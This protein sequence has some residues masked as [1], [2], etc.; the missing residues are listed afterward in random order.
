MPDKRL[1]SVY[2]AVNSY[3]QERRAERSISTRRA[4][5]AI[6]LA[7]PHVRQSDVELAELVAKAAMRSGRSVLFD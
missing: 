1:P 5:T 4:V 7:A 3:L 6:R 2:S